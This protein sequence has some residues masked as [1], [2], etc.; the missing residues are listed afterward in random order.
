MIDVF[1]ERL[2]A[3]GM[4]Q[5]RLMSVAAIARCNCM[6]RYHGGPQMPAIRRD[7]GERPGKGNWKAVY[8]FFNPS[9]EEIEAPTSHE[10]IAGAE[11]QKLMDDRGDVY[12]GHMFGPVGISPS[13]EKQIADDFDREF[14]VGGGNDQAP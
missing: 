4:D 9:G 3:L 12:I 6:V 13:L 1:K 14:P 8:K 5:D 11:I 10:M 2:I 7:V